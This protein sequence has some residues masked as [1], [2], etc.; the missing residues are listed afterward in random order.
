MVTQ[1]GFRDHSERVAGVVSCC[2][3]SEGGAESWGAGEAAAWLAGRGL[4]GAAGQLAGLGGSQLLLL[5]EREVRA[6]LGGGILSKRAW[7]ELRGL[8][9]AVSPAH[10]ATHAV[11]AP[12]GLQ[13]FTH[14]LVA[15]GL[16]S[17]QWS[18]L[19]LPGLP[20]ALQRA[21]VEHAGHRVRI[22]AVIH[23]E[24]QNRLARRASLVTTVMDQRVEVVG[25]HS[26][27]TL[28]SLVQ[29]YLTTRGVTCSEAG[30]GENCLVV[31]L[32]R[33]GEAELEAEGG[34][35]ARQALQMADRTG[36]RVVTVVEEAAPNPA[37]LLTR[38]GAA[39]V[40]W[41]HDYQKAVIDRLVNHIKES[42]IRTKS[43]LH[44]T[45]TCGSTC[46]CTFTCNTRTVPHLSCAQ[47]TLRSR[48][49]SVDSG[50]ELF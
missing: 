30:S 39:K 10:P 38:P 28:V 20:T 18:E 25:P 3:V 5:T 14:R 42:N 35:E 33:T 7:R 32:G 16:G 44:N 34:E 9:R 36:A 23:Q 17:E 24:R 27:R 43:Y 41:L 21:G 19:D 6:R 49:I 40:T 11:L 13:E 26:S 4:G 45:C 8:S 12:A 31:V 37:S 47:E 2:A 1:S 22:T 48:S 29:L 50:I 15:A 46:S